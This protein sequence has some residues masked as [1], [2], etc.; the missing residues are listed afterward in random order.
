MTTACPEAGKYKCAKKKTYGF[1]WWCCWF[2][3]AAINVRMGFHC[4]SFGV[5]LLPFF[6]RRQVAIMAPGE[7]RSFRHRFLCRSASGTAERSRL[8]GRRKQGEALLRRAHTLP[9]CMALSR[10]VPCQTSIPALKWDPAISRDG[11]VLCYVCMYST[12]S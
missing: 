11:A 6:R 12:G 9:C 3:V 7:V 10:A 8:R 5:F 4:R 1:S 2:P